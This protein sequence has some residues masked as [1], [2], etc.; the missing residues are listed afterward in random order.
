MMKCAQHMPANVNKFNLV[1]EFRGDRISKAVINRA[2]SI[3]A[4][5]SSFFSPSS[6]NRRIR[7]QELHE[8]VARRFVDEML[9]G[10]P[11]KV[12]LLAD[13]FA[14]FLR[15]LKEQGLEP[16][17]RSDFKALVT[18]MIRDQFNVCLRND[19]KIDE[20]QG[21]RGWKNVGYLNQTVPE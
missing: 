5:D 21:V 9:C 2:R 10:E 19:L 6:P 14:Q 15:L 20:R 3:L 17:K 4:A 8:R 16:V 1:Q 7:G 11:G 18:P 13:A 12:L